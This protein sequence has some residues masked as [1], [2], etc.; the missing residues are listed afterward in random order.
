MA[1]HLTP[2]LADGRLLVGQ[3]QARVGQLGGAVARGGE[4]APQRR[5]RAVVL[6]QAPHHARHRGRRLA[7][8]LRLVVQ[9]IGYW[10]G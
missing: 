10:V 8:R 1:L 9:C 2:E 5:Q 3:L 6:R 4:L 7:Q